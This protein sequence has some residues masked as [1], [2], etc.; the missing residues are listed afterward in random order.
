[1]TT[2]DPQ[3]GLRRYSDT[4]CIR[5]HKLN[6]YA[7]VSGDYLFDRWVY[8]HFNALILSLLAEILENFHFAPCA[9]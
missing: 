2:R 4:Y 3:R 5:L 6:N 8:A 9:E 7:L 1:M